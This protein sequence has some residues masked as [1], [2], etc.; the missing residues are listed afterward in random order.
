MPNLAKD[1]TKL[2]KHSSELSY[3]PTSYFTKHDLLKLF[4]DFRFVLDKEES[5]KDFSWYYIF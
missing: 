5:K 3:Y 2:K 1:Y 4:K